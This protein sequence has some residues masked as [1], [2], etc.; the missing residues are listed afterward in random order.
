VNYPES[1]KGAIAHVI[2]YSPK[3][4]RGSERPQNF[5]PHDITNLIILCNP[6]HLVVDAKGENLHVIKMLRGWKRKR[7]EWVKGLYKKMFA[8]L[9]SDLLLQCADLLTPNTGAQCLVASP[10][11][12]LSLGAVDRLCALGDCAHDATVA[13]DFDAFIKIGDA[14]AHIGRDQRQRRIQSPG[15]NLMAEGVRLAAL[16]DG[17]RSASKLSEVVGLY[18]EALDLDPDSPRNLRGLGKA[19][20]DAGQIGRADEFYSKACDRAI[21]GLETAGG[22]HALFM[23]EALRSSRHMISN[24][25]VKGRKLTQVKRE[26]VI[27]DLGACRARH[28]LLLRKFSHYPRWKCIETFMGYTIMGQAAAALRLPK[29]RQMLAIAIQ[30]ASVTALNSRQAVRPPSANSG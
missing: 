2:A 21:N 4:T 18:E 12:R 26:T 17:D 5:D 10:E 20:Q 23:H 25:L 7:E 30:I 11:H 22:Q 28:E 3:A 16:R 19:Y 1:D 8:E 14:I 6:H 29:S 9:S 24:V 15:V 27:E 13:G